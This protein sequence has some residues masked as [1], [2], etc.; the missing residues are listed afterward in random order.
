MGDRGCAR[1]LR[2]SPLKM[3]GLPRE[4]FNGRVRVVLS[5]C[6]GLSV[7]ESYRDANGRQRD[8]SG[9]R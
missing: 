6:A 8:M 1:W 2:A 9:W 5:V 7:S 4:V 3:P